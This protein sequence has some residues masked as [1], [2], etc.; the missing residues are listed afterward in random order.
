VVSTNSG[1]CVPAYTNLF[2]YDGWNLAS[3]VNPNGSL[4]TA[5]IWGTDLSGSL[6]GAGGAGGLLA[7]NLGTNGIH[8]VADDANG[9]VTALLYTG[10]GAVYANYEYS[11]FGENIWASGPVAAFNPIR[12]S[13]KFE[14]PESGLYYYG[15]RYYNPS[16]G[17]WLSKD[18]IEEQGGNNLYGLVGNHPTFDV[19][20][21]GLDEIDN[22]CATLNQRL[23]DLNEQWNLLNDAEQAARDAFNNP[24]TPANMRNFDHA[25]YQIF[26][27]DEE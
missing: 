26:R 16:T 17:R 18:P 25:A 3:V 6:Q 4:V 9:N 22:I 1:S 13:S 14:D 20:L 12:F 19:D 10:N 23:A 24:N 27:G 5:M 2:L 8:F 11:P 15:Y 21:L 7:V